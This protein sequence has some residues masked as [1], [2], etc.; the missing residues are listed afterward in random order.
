[1]AVL[2][3]HRLIKLKSIIDVLRRTIPG[4]QSERLLER[5]S[6]LYTTDPSEC[7]GREHES[8]IAGEVAFE[9]ILKSPVSDDSEGV[10]YKSDDTL[11]FTRFLKAQ[12]V[13]MPFND[14]NEDAIA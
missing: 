6:G 9:Q 1:M 8:G 7:S 10:P 3:R 11:R 2:F 12:L 14:V 4:E 5:F 13:P